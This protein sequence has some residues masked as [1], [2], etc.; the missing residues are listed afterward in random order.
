MVCEVVYMVYVYRRE[1]VTGKINITTAS[2]WGPIL[3]EV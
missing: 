3:I 2:G 1:K